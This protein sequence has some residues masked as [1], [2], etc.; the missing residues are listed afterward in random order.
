MSPTETDHYSVLQLN[1]DETPMEFVVDVLQDVFEMDRDDAI[2]LMFSVHTD[3]SAEC[4]Q[5]AYEEANRKAA[6]VIGLARE[7]RHL[8]QCMVKRRAK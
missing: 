3:G 1:D 6:E 2:N 7:H 5:F 8:L 4:G